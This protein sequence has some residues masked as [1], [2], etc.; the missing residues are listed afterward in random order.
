MPEY[1]EIQIEGLTFRIRKNRSLLADSII[2]KTFIR[3]KSIGAHDI[4]K[5]DCEIFNRET[6]AW[7]KVIDNDLDNVTRQAGRKL[8]EKI[9][10]LRKSEKDFPETQP[11]KKPEDITGS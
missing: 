9:T 2:E 1:E 10:E 4:I 8:I 3:D 7:R 11:E 5:V 6:K